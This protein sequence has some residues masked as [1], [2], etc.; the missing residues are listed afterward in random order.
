VVIRGAT[1][2]AL[3]ASMSNTVS[4]LRDVVLV[5]DI[6]HWIQQEDPVAT[7]EALLGFLRSL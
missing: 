4:D 6:G 7:N 1:A 2:A 3:T 5:P